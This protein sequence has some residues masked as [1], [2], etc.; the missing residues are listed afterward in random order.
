MEIKGFPDGLDV[1]CEREDSKMILRFLF[2]IT[3]MME[4]PLRWE[5]W[6]ELFLMR[7]SEV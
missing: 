7:R 6:G 2:L 5:G 1:K 3:R 4:L